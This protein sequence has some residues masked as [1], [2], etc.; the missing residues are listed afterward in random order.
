MDEPY[1]R[2]HPQVLAD[3]RAAARQLLAADASADVILAT[4]GALDVRHGIMT[5]DAPHD[6]ERQTFRCDPY[7]C[8]I[9]RGGCLER[10]AVRSQLAARGMI[11]LAEDHGVDRCTPECPQGQTT[12]DLLGVKTAPT[13]GTAGGSGGDQPRPMAGQ[14]DAVPQPGGEDPPKVQDA[15][16]AGKTPVAERR[17]AAAAAARRTALN[18]TCEICGTR[19]HQMFGKP[20][21]VCK[22]QEC[23]LILG[24]A[25]NHKWSVQEQIGWENVRAQ[26]P[27][28]TPHPVPEAPVG[29]SAPAVAPRS[30]MVAP[31]RPKPKAV[32][33]PAHV[34]GLLEAVAG[35]TPA[36]V[37]FGA[38]PA[39]F[40]MAAYHYVE[41]HIHRP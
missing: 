18:R 6:P 9:T 5:T 21:S 22:A 20:S 19:F 24:R 40:V 8:T 29:A 4:F 2:F 39:W 17:R 33:A 15:A 34:P 31:T 12:R 26:Q 35:A 3:F 30:R 13:N 23:R 27:A 7:A 25:R 41:E 36:T 32:A 14:P 1:R 11:A 16:P 10:Q 38:L 28:G 37:D